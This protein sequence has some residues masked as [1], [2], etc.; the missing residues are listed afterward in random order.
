MEYKQINPTL[1]PYAK[2]HYCG[3]KNFIP[4]GEFM[5][6]PRIPVKH[7][8]VS[9]EE[10]F[11]CDTCMDLR[12]SKIGDQMLLYAKLHPHKPMSSLKET[13][14]DRISYEEELKEE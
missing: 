2:C 7:V 14:V 8:E 4:F 13:M 1:L 6:T 9:E 11:I 10:R 3:I 5:Y 12:R